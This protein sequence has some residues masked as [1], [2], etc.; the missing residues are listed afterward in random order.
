MLSVHCRSYMRTMRHK[1]GLLL[2][3]HDS[4]E[5][6]VQALLQ[7]RLQACLIAAIMS[8]QAFPEPSEPCIL[9]WLRRPEPSSS[10]REIASPPGHLISLSIMLPADHARDGRGFHQCLPLPGGGA[11]TRGISRTKQSHCTRQRPKQQQ[12]T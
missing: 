6:L 8:L 5:Q 10:H 1:L 3:E 7:V 12:C 4:D 11:F 2:L 9:D